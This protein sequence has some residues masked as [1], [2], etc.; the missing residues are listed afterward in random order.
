MFAGNS[1]RNVPVSN[2]HVYANVGRCQSYVEERQIIRQR[3]TQT[4]TQT[5][6][7][8]YAVRSLKSTSLHL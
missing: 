4:D 3:E 8:R 5:H 6:G 1:Q 7:D 2:I